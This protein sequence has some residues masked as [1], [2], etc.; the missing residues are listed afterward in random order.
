MTEFLPHLHP[1]I[2]VVI[3]LLLFSFPT[4]AETH[5]AGLSSR[6]ELDMQS[7]QQTVADHQQ[8]W[9]ALRGRT[10]DTLRAWQM[11]GYSPYLLTAQRLGLTAVQN[12]QGDT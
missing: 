8:A 4:Q 11:T 2:I 3:L 6:A 12:E 9:L 10:T 1:S 7:A 5:G